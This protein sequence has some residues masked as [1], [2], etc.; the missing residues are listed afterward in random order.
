M[1]FLDDLNRVD[2]VVEV[3]RRYSS[4]LCCFGMVDV[5]F[6]FSND[7]VL[8]T[9]M[10]VPGILRSW[11]EPSSEENEVSSAEKMEKVNE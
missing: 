10:L 9:C 4:M 2:Q 8:P 11:S 7:K 3:S 6:M 5:M 1:T